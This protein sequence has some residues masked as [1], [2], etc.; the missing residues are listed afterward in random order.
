MFRK[1]IYTFIISTFCNSGLAQNS[2]IDSLKSLLIN[3][4]KPVERFD[5]LNNL[6]LELTGWKGD[7]VDSSYCVQM[8]HIAQD[9][10][11]DSLLAISYN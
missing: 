11:N 9:L 10:K 7:N 6:T 1:L 4:N 2:T 3:T 8:L 5:I